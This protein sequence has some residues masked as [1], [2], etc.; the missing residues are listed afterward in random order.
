MRA[1]LGIDPGV[2]GGLAVLAPGGKV[3][4]VQGFKPEMT[5]ADLVH[6]VKQGVEALLRFGSDSCFIEKVGFKPGDGGMGAFTFGRVDGLLRGAA[7]AFGLTVREVSPVMWQSR[8]GCLT[9]GNKNVSKN[10][11][12]SLFPDIKITHAIADALLIA[13]HGRRCLIGRGNEFQTG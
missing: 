4:F 3:L 13:E 2:R 6:V 7:L 9:G 5:Q 8:M 10:K 12:L 11:A 1:V